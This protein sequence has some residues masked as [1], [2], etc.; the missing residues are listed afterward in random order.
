MLV[1]LLRFHDDTSLLNEEACA[2]R[3][4]IFVTLLVSQDSIF[5]L[6]VLTVEQ[7]E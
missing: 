3:Y 5:S 7:Y 4:I 1:T 2:N 6:N